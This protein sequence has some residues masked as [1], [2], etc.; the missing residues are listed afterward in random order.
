MERTLRI[1]AVFPAGSA[2]GEARAAVP[3]R[4][5]R[6]TVPDTPSRAM[7]IEVARTRSGPL[8][9]HDLEP[10]DAL[11]VIRRVAAIS[12][13]NGPVP[14]DFDYTRREHGLPMLW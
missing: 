7:P 8:A 5:C 2:P 3:R 14:D 12:A 1:H 10:G 4:G 13:A 6:A 9:T 11:R